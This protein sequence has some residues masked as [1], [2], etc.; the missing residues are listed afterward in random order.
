MG[1]LVRDKIPEIIKEGGKDCEVHEA[2]D[3][4]YREFFNT[5]RF[6]ACVNSLL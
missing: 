1:K 4:E 2:R 3:V 6:V 5:P